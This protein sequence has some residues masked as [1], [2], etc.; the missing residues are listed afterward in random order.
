[1]TVE[2]VRAEQEKARQAQSD[3]AANMQRR[4]AEADA[5][6]EAREQERADVNAGMWRVVEQL[7]RNNAA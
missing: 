6:N 4:L 1:M 3:F 7:R 2:D 5:E